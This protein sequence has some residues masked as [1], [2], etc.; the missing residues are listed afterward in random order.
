MSHLAHIRAV[1]FD[2]GG[3]LIE[4]WPSVGA[5]Y[6]AVAAECGWRGLDAARV[7]R[8][9]A[10]AWE[11][12]GRF[13]YSREAWFGLVRASFA[14]LAEP[15]E[16]L[17][18]AIYERFGHAGAWRIHD[19]VFPA[20]DA[21]AARDLRLG[22][23]SNWDERLR[24]LLGELGLARRF[25]VVTV[26]GEAGC[27]KPA[28]GIFAAAARA[29]DLP[30]AS[31][32]HVGDRAAEDVAGARTAGFHAVRLR[33]GGPADDG[34]IDSLPALAGLRETRRRPERMG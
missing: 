9:F 18:A 24:P 25:E 12:R 15:T 32:L 1:T 20:L 33:R 7:D 16:D 10:A 23:I 2:V 21:L 34:T 19:D 29:F 11:Q 30:P 17:F 22:V 4:P 8:Q 31:I 14:G 6:C 13:D 26:S 3:T 27:A 5:V 28:H